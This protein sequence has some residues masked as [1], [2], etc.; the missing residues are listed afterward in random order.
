MYGQPAADLMTA[1]LAARTEHD[2]LLEWVQIGS[3]AG[4]KVTLP[5]NYLRSNNLRLLGSGLGSIAAATFGKELFLLAQLIAAGNFTVDNYPVPLTE[6]NEENWYE[7]QHRVVYL[8]NQPWQAQP[9]LFV[10]KIKF[11][12]MKTVVSLKLKSGR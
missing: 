11:A 2:R 5:A 7:N 1:L 3:I 8:P 9:V 4:P 10:D 6:L 12:V